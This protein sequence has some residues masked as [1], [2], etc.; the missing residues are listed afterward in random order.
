M[1]HQEAPAV[2]PGA[3]PPPAR[4]VAINEYCIRM[5]HLPVQLE[6]GSFRKETRRWVPPR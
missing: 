6:A 1:P 5:L 2:V 4:S 3:T